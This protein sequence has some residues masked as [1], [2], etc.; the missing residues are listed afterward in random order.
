MNII[1]TKKIVILLVILSLF[2][3]AKEETLHEKEKLGF[4]SPSQILL[5]ENFF[6]WDSIAL[7]NDFVRL[8][9]VPEL[10]GKIMGYDF[11]G[12]QVIWHDPTMEGVVDHDQGYKQGE[13]WVN[14]GGAKIWP[15]PQGRGEGQW[16]GPPDNVLDAA[17]YEYTYDEKTITVISPK[18]DGEGRSGLQYR[19]TY[20]LLPSSTVVN[21]D[22]TMANVV[23]RPVKWSLWLLATLPA[24]PKFTI[25]VPVDKGNW[26]VMYGDE[27]NPQWE[28]VED[29]IFRARYKN[30]TGKVGMIAR[31]GWATWF[32]E[33]K[34]MVFAMMFDIEESAEYPDKGSNVEIWMLGSDVPEK[35]NVELEALGP[36][37]K[38]SPGGT[39]SSNVKWGVCHASAVKRVV[40]AG[41]IAEELALT[42]GTIKGKLGVFYSGRMQAL[43]FDQQGRQIGLKNL[44]EASPKAEI[45]VSQALTDIPS[46][47]HRV[48]F[49][50]VNDAT[51]FIGVLGDVQLKDL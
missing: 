50:L 6:G 1:Q 21:L 18:D 32:D 7:R 23:D 22:L 42:D 35:N 36:L 9:I 43:Y 8:D 45:H 44:M 25:Y 20:S 29:G 17:A 24:D 41:V 15:A 16:S 38:L 49:Q 13:K 34:G 28:G 40:P 48:R 33:K 2:S 51:E 39:V 10:G 3:C 27:K 5:N 4:S 14:P 47:V 26:H 19:H 37:L 46:A 31:E 30:F 12:Y 11:Q